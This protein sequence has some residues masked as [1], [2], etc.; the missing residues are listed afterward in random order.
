MIVSGATK[1]GKT[2][3]VKRPLVW[4]ENMM[5][6]VPKKV[7]FCYKYWQLSYTEMAKTMPETFHQGMP[8]DLVRSNYFDPN[9]PNLI[10]FE[11]LMRTEGAHHRDIS[12]VF[13]I[14]SLFIQGKQSITISV[15]AHYFILLKNLQDRQQVEAFGRPV[16]PRK[17]H[18]FSEAYEKATMRPHG[19]LVVDLYPTTPDSCRLRNIFPGENHQFHPNDIFYTISPIAELYKEKN[20]ME[21]AELKKCITVRH[22]LILWWNVMTF[23]LR[24]R[25]KK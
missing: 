5:I 18:T 3:W 4:K 19:Y 17:S 6:P 24:S 16:Y 14:K 1:S 2:E 22:K 23:P 13:I 20:Y 9:A 11:D 21:S 7:L 10:A 8:N 25:N 12:V 15:N